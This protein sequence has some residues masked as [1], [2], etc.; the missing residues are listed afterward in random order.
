V[1]LDVLFDQRLAGLDRPFVHA[2]HGVMDIAVKEFSVV[3]IEHDLPDGRAGALRHHA[4]NHAFAFRHPGAG[5]PHDRYS[6][7]ST[8]D[9]FC[10]GTS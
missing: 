2:G 6:P 7:A 4:V 1:G 5:K 9:Y 10:S 3:G 8:G